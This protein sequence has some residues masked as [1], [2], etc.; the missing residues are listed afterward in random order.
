MT[1]KKTLSVMTVEEFQKHM[2]SELTALE[3]TP[4]KD[5][6]TSLKNSM[7][8]Y[9]A[10]EKKDEHTRIPVELYKTDTAGDITALA[11]RFDGLEKKLDELLG[12]KKEGG[13]EELSE[14]DK[15]KKEEEAKK[16]AD[17]EEAKKAEKEAADKK[18]E[19]DK[20][21]EEEAK[22]NDSGW[23]EDMGHKVLSPAEAV[24]AAKKK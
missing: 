8:F 15:K 6:H 16:A 23:D 11:A 5:R 20:K 13:E 17:E 22:K 2:D 19:E 3:A 4:N 24:A 1:D 10:V 9:N 7:A 12:K 18:A 21:K 14:E